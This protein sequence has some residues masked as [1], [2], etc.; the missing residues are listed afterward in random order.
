MTF[1]SLCFSLN[2]RLLNSCLLGLALTSLPLIVLRFFIKNFLFRYKRFLFEEK[3][4]I[5]SKLWGVC[6]WAMK[7]GFVLGV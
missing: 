1:F 6:F 4:S 7:V 5:L 3:P 2:S